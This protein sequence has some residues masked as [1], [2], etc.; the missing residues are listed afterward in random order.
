MVLDVVAILVVFTVYVGLRCFSRPWI[1]H[2]SQWRGVLSK[3]GVTMG[4]GEGEKAR[5]KI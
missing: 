2:Q 3:D 5:D 1:C 4:S